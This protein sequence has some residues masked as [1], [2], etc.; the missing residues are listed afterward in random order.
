MEAIPTRVLIQA[1][2]RDP[3]VFDVY[4]VDLKSGKVD[5][6]TENPG[7]VQGWQADNALQVRAAQVSTDRM[8]EPSSACAM[9]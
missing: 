9:T 3:K 1:N 4:R 8:A 5:L 2:K 7:D 6:D